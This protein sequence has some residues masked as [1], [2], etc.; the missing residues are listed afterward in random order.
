MIA[1]GGATRRLGDMFVIEFQSRDMPEVRCAISPLF[2]LWQSVGALQTPE[3]KDVLLPWI[4]DTLDRTR[5]LQLELLYALQPPQGMKPDFIHPPPTM[6]MTSLEDE[7]DRLIA[8]EVDRIRGDLELC[9]PDSL[10]PVLGPFLTDPRAAL[11]EL[12]ECL[13]GYWN[14]AL[15]PHWERLRAV[16]EGD[17]LSRARDAE[18]GPSKLFDD[19]H[20]SVSFVD[21]RLEICAPW[22]GRL[23]LGDQGL[24]LVPSVFVWPRVAVIDHEP[25]QPTIIYPVRGGALLWEPLDGA[26]DALAALIGPRRATVLT[27]LEAPR[28]TTELAQLLAM[29]QASVSQHLSVLHAGGLITRH[30]V[31]RSV[32]YLRSAKGDALAG[33]RRSHA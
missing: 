31:G 23:T 28:S 5:D 18:G 3:S 14:M 4:A 12:A 13:W 11:K 17:V 33:K 9:Y 1:S 27:A 22:D 16:L 29:S 24:L 8:T 30:R 25:W 19:I 21:H 2:E 6:P 20:E 15:A 10:P 32:L 26:P 7:L